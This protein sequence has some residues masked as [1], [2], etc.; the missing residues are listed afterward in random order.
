MWVWVESP[1]SVYDVDFLQYNSDTED[2]PAAKT[3]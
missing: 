2:T 3:S 1:S